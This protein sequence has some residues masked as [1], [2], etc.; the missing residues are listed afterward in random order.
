MGTHNVQGSKE[1]TSSIL[2][3]GVLIINIFDFLFRYDN[4]SLPVAGTLS[5]L[6]RLS[7]KS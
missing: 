1:T 7:L 6:L 2:G 5:D 3:R 4:G